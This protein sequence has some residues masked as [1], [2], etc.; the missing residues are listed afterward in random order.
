MIKPV[1][2]TE[3][4]KKDLNSFI[5]YSRNYELSIASVNKLVILKQAEIAEEKF[6]D[7]FRKVLN[8][9]V[10]EKTSWKEVA[11]KLKLNGQNEARVLFSQAISYLYN[12][13]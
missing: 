3:L 12:L 6:P 5:L 8:L 9:K 13:K 4:D 10:M 7:H 2:L 11:A 1:K